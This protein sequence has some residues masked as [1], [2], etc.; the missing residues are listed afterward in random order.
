M[1]RYLSWHETCENIC[2]LDASVYNDKQSQ[3]SDKCICGYKELIDKGRCDDGII[4]N[5]SICEC[6]CD[7]SCYVA[8]HLD[9]ANQKCRK[10]MIDKLV[11]ECKDEILSTADTISNA[12][13]TL[14]HWQTCV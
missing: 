2:R 6:E 3:N 12:D 5:P 11:L 7:K 4:W 14:C 8:Q 10:A 9:H 13:K 1:K